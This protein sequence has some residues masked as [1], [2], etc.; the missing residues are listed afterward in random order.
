M[1]DPSFER[2]ALAVFEAMLDVEEG[3]RETW[4]ETETGSDVALK[5][6]VTAIWR[7]EKQLDLKTGAYLDSV[8]PIA[9]PE[10]IGA[11]RITE[12]I[13]SG[14]MGTVFAAERDA[15]DFE[16]SVAIKLIKPGV[17]TDQLVA[18]FNR[19]RQILANLNHPHIAR[20]FDGGTSEQG[21]PYI[22]MERI[23]GVPLLDWLASQSPSLEARLDLFLQVCAAAGHAH[24]NLVVHRDLTPANVLVDSAGDAKLIDFGIARPEGEEYASTLGETEASQPIR[25]ITMTPGYAAPERIKGDAATVLSDVYSAGKMLEAMLPAARS[26]ELE[27]IIA[28]AIADS[29]DARYLS[30]EQLA[31][32]VRAV[33]TSHPVGAMPSG[34][35]YRWGKWF[36]RNRALAGVGAALVVALVA[37]SVTTGWFWSQ[38]V[39]ARDDA[40][41]R[42]DEVRGIA[43]FMLFDLYDE[44]EPV[45]GNTKALSQIADEARAYLERLS[46]GDDVSP[47]LRLEIAKGYHRLAAVS[48]NPY[49]PNLGR[50]EE[51]VTFVERAL[52]DLEALHKEDPD[53]ADV[54]TALARSLNL[55]SIFLFATEEESEKAVEVARRSA[56]LYEGVIGSG[57]DDADLRRS[58]YESRLQAA[59]PLLWI[60]QGGKG[61]EAMEALVA[62]IEKDPALIEG[63]PAMRRQLAGAYS[64][65]GYTR[66][67]HIPAE[68]DGY[69]SASAALDNALEIYEDLFA[70]GPE[71]EREK[72]RLSLSAALFRRSLIDSDLGSNAKA[73]T[74]LDRAI[75]LVEVITVQDPDD[76]GAASR[77]D[78]LQGQKVYVLIAMKRFNE[79]ERL[80]RIVL[81]N[82]IAR[83]ERD[84]E[85]IGWLRDVATGRQA[86]AQT[87]EEAGKSAEACI[88]YRQTL[89]EWDEIGKEIEI[90]SVD[91][92]NSIDLIKKSL[93]KC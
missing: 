28:K 62:D 50:R 85:S 60:D 14:G 20:L 24:R 58:W 45:S 84:S 2:R 70:N 44:L 26:P 76:E 54:A 83:R 69:A 46:A 31:N 1:T 92:S 39:E 53:S 36:A 72:Y 81:T 77:I 19:E 49:V 9:A 11:Y 40:N 93:R 8:D 23:D 87:L 30:M 21:Q 91:K 15:G 17:F 64:E 67:W 37:G 89:K 61:I 57:R 51:A 48:G 42:F 33:L 13:G 25:A 65:L 75:K 6:R 59:K 34:K 86:L 55:R 68:V 63:E 71:I 5:R 74:Y 78:T 88:E 22:V 80:S 47:E 12:T 73:I 10:R 16:H 82:R 29:P 90:S 56:S 79:A 27:A 18:R 7:A 32:D 4:L 52:K 66:S 43:T 41:A 38:A 35:R 3:A